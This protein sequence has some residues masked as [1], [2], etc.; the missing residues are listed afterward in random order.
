MADAMTLIGGLRK[1]LNH[2]IDLLQCV[3]SPGPI[4]FPLLKRFGLREQGN[5][6]IYKI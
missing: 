1:R 4:R 5:D 6:Y 2:F 3:L